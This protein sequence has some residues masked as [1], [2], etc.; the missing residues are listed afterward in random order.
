M[1]FI[2]D[3]VG[4]EDVVLVHRALGGDDGAFRALVLR[5][6]DR[7]F[8]LCRSRLDSD[9]E[10]EDAA[11]DSFLRAYRSLGRF[12]LG[13]SFAAWL[14][15]I[16]VN[17]SRTRASQTAM[18]TVK[19]ARAASEA[20]VNAPGGDPAEAVEAEAEFQA[21][22]AAVASLPDE[23]RL[24]VQLYYFAGLSVAEISKERGLGAEAVKSRLFRA[25]K[26]LR[27]I[28]ED[29]NRGGDTEV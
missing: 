23:L 8:R 13:E 7:L 4:I 22:R 18:E 27:S 28:L 6:G 26:K 11:Q 21:L 2:M 25:R 16:A 10:A 1:S 29:D 3:E 5:Y 17:R 15:G 9:E 12:R 20:E 19:T 24:P 14:F